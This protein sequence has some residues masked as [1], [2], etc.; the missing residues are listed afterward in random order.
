[1]TSNHGAGPPPAV[2]AAFGLNGHV[3][4]LAG[5][6]GECFLLTTTAAE[7]I[8]LKPVLSPV[9][10][11]FVCELQMRLLSRKPTQY[12]IA[13]PVR[14]RSPIM[15]PLSAQPSLAFGGSPDHQPQELYYT[16]P[17]PTE[18]NSTP[19]CWTA[20]HFISGNG[21]PTV[22]PIL[23]LEA[24][25]A[26]HADLLHLYPPSST[27]PPP[28][29]LARTDRWAWADHY[30]WSEISLTSIPNLESSMLTRLQPHLDRL[31]ALLTLSPSQLAQDRDVNV[32]QRQLIHADLSGNLLFS[33][34]PDEVQSLRPGIIDFSPLWRPV[35][36]AE[37]IVAADLLL[38]RKG[39]LE[40]IREL[41]LLQGQ[42]R[43]EILVRAT[44]FRVVTFAIEVDWGFVK[45]NL[46]RLDLQGTIAALE[47]I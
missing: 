31:T 33:N 13:E 43:Q 17:S 25:R 19:T 2:L 6:Q 47:E 34:P 22:R 10:T 42:G 40:S 7:R 4:P 8:V 20:T 46:D 35:A 36:Y 37:A 26:M 24:S 23:L 3:S 5:G 27:P 38:W 9:E 29:I 32:S 45:R 30:A 15:K 14:L 12:R 28:A 18:A 21:C 39:D 44:L 41:G 11:E 16:C 1:M